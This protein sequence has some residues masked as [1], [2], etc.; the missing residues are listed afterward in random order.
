MKI[1][2]VL[3]DPDSGPAAVYLTR[4]EADKHCEIFYGC[5]VDEREID[6]LPPEATQGLHLYLVY[7]RQNH[8]GL[9]HVY[10]SPMSENADAYTEETTTKAALPDRTFVA[11]LWAKDKADASKQA[12]QQVKEMY[13][14]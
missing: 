11:R 10:T 12:I 5:E 6:H 9:H 1:Y 4:E 8:A 7:L 3:S 14:P 2:L 13:N